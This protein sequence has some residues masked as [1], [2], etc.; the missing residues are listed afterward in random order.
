MANESILCHGNAAYSSLK[1]IYLS[2]LINPKKNGTFYLRQHKLINN[3]Y[4]IDDSL[5]ISDSAQ[6]FFKGNK[7]YKGAK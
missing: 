5:H 1:L 4:V 2:K 7:N 6:H 3:L